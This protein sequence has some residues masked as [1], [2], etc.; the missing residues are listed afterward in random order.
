GRPVI[1]VLAYYRCPML[2]SQVISGL[3][4]SLRGVDLLPDRYEVLIVSFDAREKTE[5][6][7]AKRQNYLDQYSRPGAAE[8]IHFLTGDQPAINQLTKAVGFS[9]SY[10]AAKDQF[11]HPGMV[12]VLTADG[13]IARYF[14][15]IDF[16]TRNLKLGLV[17]ASEGKV[18]TV[19]DQVVLF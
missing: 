11:A 1:L 3:F 10:D 13:R 6:A 18:G 12:T 4:E 7:S 8:H 2:C 16:P 17:E 9:Y 14:F 5:L 15:G 19:I